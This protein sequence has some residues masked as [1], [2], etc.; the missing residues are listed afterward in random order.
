MYDQTENA[1][2]ELEK[3][4]AFDAEFAEKSARLAE[5]DAMHNMDEPP[6]LALIGVE[7]GK[8]APSAGKSFTLP[9][10]GRNPAGSGES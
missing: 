6:E 1:K 10:T 8:A 9:G 2:A 3:P 7:T 4:F 5:L